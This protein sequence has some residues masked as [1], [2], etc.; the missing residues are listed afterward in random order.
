MKS[1]QMKTLM[2]ILSVVVLTAFITS[3]SSV[4]I[5]SRGVNHEAKEI[6]N[7]T[8][9]KNA[10]S[11]NILFSWVEQSVD[12]LA[13][14]V[15]DELES[16]ERLQNDEEYREQYTK[17]IEEVALNHAEGV[18][19]ALSVFLRLN[20][21]YTT[22]TAGMF[23][24][25]EDLGEDF[26]EIPTTDLSAYETTERDIVGWYYEPVEKGEPVWM[27]PYQNGI[28]DKWII[29]Y[30]EPVY[31]DG[32]LIGVI[33]MDIDFK[34]IEEEAAKIHVYDT[35]YAFITGEDGTLMYHPRYQYGDA[36]EQKDKSLLSA[37]QE[38]RK[39]NESKELLTYEIEGKRICMAYCK[40]END[41]IFCISVPEAEINGE[42]NE[43]I[44]KN[45]IVTVL[46]AFVAGIAGAFFGRHLV[47]PLKELNVV[48]KR[49]AEGNFDVS[50][51]CTSD[52]EVGELAD[53]LRKMA[54]YLKKYVSTLNSLAYCDS[55][56]GV[57]NKTA[58]HEIE[59]RLDEKIAENTAHFAVAVF[60]VNNLK[61]TN[62][63][64]GHMT[65]D[66]LIIKVSK[67]I[68]QT[69]KHSP[70]FRIGGDEFVAIL[71]T[72]DFDEYESLVEQFRQD[73]KMQRMKE[74]PELPVSV[75][76]G[77]AVYD[78]DKDRS[79]TDVFQRA[80][81][82]MYRNKIIMKKEIKRKEACGSRSGT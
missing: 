70:V 82:M 65:G 77:V 78:A 20:P 12:T 50:I 26:Q 7:L 11:L 4:L 30:V 63:F 22:P 33:G 15:E 42:R 58:Y 57:R 46:L 61:I 3:A 36:L 62:D 16:M 35:G 54:E 18:E 2:L 10:E 60:D 51:K 56:T 72:K 28:L 74:Y 67:Q 32:T 5:L 37:V 66:D 27:Q 47:K 17:K 13:I 64:Y 29:T 31:K 52:D 39:E 6:M 34:R 24:A 43:L 14:H 73:M 40:L 41:M 19:G 48:A 49:I 21:D 75:A 76:C 59:K 80:D 38:M 9:E 53:S 79:F 25:R 45:I 55:M 1:I 69:F 71:E 23:W 8:C 81:D 44:V 68:C